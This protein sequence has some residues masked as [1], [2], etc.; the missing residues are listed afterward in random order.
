M[1]FFADLHIHSH[2]SRA[3]S[4]NLNFEHLSKWAQ[5]KGITVVGTGD[6]AHPGWLQEMKDKL[7]PA[8]EGLFKLK[9]EFAAAIRSEVPAACQAPV[10]FM[11]AGEISSIYKKNEKVRK[12]HNVIFA[13][14][15]G[16]VE[17]I[18]VALE[19]IGNIRSDGRP[20]LG[21]DSRDLLEIIL[22]IDPQDYLIPAHIWTPWFSLLG[23]KSGFDSV[24]ECFD[25]LTPHIFALETGL[26]SD[27]PMN[28]RI[29][30]LDG[31]TLISNSD[32]HSPQKLAREANLF[33][34]ELSYPSIFEALKSGDPANF[35]GTTEFFPEEGKY[36][37]DGHRKCGVSWEPRTT[38]EHN[39]LCTVCGKPVTV[40]VM[41]RV[42]T[43][44]DRQVGAQSA[45]SQRYQSLIPLPCSRLAP[46]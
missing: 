34:T 28:W 18:Q 26:S 5:L 27:P 2:Y 6:I 20:I 36:H 9:D 22:D 40:G 12:V 16:A 14:S 38:I 3:T 23:S 33:D 44:A 46:N 25:D 32:A 8:E 37:Y 10:R 43:L 45:R 39:M 24:A 31:Y 17:K 30:A 19:K 35:L 13:P 41:H 29:S 15:L 21:L 4:K 11:L 1:K 7:E 42:E